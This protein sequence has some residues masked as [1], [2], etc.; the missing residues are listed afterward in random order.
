MYNALTVNNLKSKLIIYL[1]VLEKLYIGVIG[2]VMN[3]GKLIK[4]K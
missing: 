1:P 4:V 2:I 3:V